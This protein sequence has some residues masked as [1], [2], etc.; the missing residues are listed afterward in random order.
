MKNG[1][2]VRVPEAHRNALVELVDQHGAA[3]ACRLSG[4]GRTVLMTAIATGNVLPGSASIIREFM[5]S[6]TNSVSSV[7]PVVKKE[8]SPK[9]KLFTVDAKGNCILTLP[10]GSVVK[11]VQ[12]GPGWQRIDRDGN[13]QEFGL[14]FTNG[15]V[16][17]QPYR[18]RKSKRKRK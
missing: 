14:R 15:V 6:R 12:I 2:L 4:L 10:E 17:D 18:D 11:R 8:T 3:D 13:V 16:Y 5:R 1:K 7:K 9:I